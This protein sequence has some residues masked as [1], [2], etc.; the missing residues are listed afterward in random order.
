M[1]KDRPSG[2]TYKKQRERTTLT[3]DGRREREIEAI[4][5]FGADSFSVRARKYGL[6]NDQLENLIALR[7]G[8]CHL[9]LEKPWTVVDHDHK[10]CPLG[11]AKI[12]GK[13]VRGLLCAGCNV[14]MSAYDRDEAWIERAR[15]YAQPLPDEPLL[16]NDWVLVVYQKD[17]SGAAV[18]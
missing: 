7:G 1:P 16:V 9:C 4:L 6:T 13:C 17:G 12:C 11:A 10:C 3:P 14:S 8:M 5:R 18:P 2:L 15:Q